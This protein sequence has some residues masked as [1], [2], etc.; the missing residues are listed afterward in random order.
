VGTI[1]VDPRA[2]VATDADRALDLTSRE[3]DLLLYFARHPRRVFTR[4][5]LLT[6]VWG[7]GFDGYEHTVNSHINRLRAKIE[8]SPSQ[9]RHIVT[10]W[11]LGYRF[12]PD[13]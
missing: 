6:A 1:Y 10:V 9:P 11:G 5:Q 4:E 2:R 3:F 13:T 7:A 8:H 12:E